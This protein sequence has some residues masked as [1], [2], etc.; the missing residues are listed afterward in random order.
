MTEAQRAALDT[1]HEQG[2]TYTARTTSSGSINKRAAESLI[3]L[4]Y[5]RWKDDAGWYVEITPKGRAA[6]KREIGTR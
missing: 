2:W 4:G 3:A 6:W 1:L 5:A